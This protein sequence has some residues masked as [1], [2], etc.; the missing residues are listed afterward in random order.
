MEIR[1]HSVINNIYDWARTDTS[2]MNVYKDPNATVYNTIDNHSGP[3][4]KRDIPCDTCPNAD[5]CA[6]K[7]LECSAFRNWSARGDYSDSDVQRH[8]RAAK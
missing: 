3:E 6:V 4:N 7:L 2:F 1:K 8:I 5:D